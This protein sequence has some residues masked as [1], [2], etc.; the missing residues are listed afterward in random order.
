MLSLVS[1]HLP[2]NSFFLK[3]FCL[4]SCFCKPRN[5]GFWSTSWHWWFL[6]FLVMISHSSLEKLF[7]CSTITETKER[8][9]DWRVWFI[10]G[11]SLFR[12]DTT[13]INISIKNKITSSISKD[14][15]FSRQPPLS[16]TSRIKVGIV[17]LWRLRYRI[18]GLFTVTYS[19]IL[20][21][22]TDK[23]F[24]SKCF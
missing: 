14:W 1:L 8:I 24:P 23:C 6:R 2:Y 17:G 13:S 15:S 22:I 7:L 11:S 18:C 5:F 12:S 9:V 10:C 3:F 4:F 16:L 20:A 21:Y 19:W